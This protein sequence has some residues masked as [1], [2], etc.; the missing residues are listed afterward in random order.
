MGTHLKTAMPCQLWQHGPSWPRRPWVPDAGAGAPRPL[1]RR[2]APARTPQ[3]QERF[4]A[5][6]ALAL[7][8]FL[9]YF[10][11]EGSPVRKLAGHRGALAA[12]R[13]G[14]SR[15]SALAATHPRTISADDD[16]RKRKAFASGEDAPAA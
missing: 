16:P 13:C 3:T 7:L 14:R 6:L 10:T 9:A 12:S 2:V 4:L 1:A 8:S 5:A 11:T 15:A